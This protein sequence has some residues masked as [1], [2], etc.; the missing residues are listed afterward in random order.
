MKID[1]KNMTGELRLSS[2]HTLIM[3]H[4]PPKINVEAL[5]A[6]LDTGSNT[7]I[8]RFG[9]FEIASPNYSTYYPD[10]T[11]EDLK[12]QEAD[13]IMPVFRLL[14]E[15]IV[16]KGAPIDFSKKNVL[17]DSMKMLLGQTINIDH[18]VAVGNAIG[19]VSEVFWQNSYKDTEGRA[20]P[21]GINGVLKIDGKSNPRIARGIMMDPP[22]IHSNSVT[23]RF[24][25]EPSHK[26][27]QANEFYD[28][29]GTY[30]KDG[31]LVRLIVTAIKSYHETSL[32]SHGADV[33]AQKV[34]ENGK[35]VNP[36]YANTVY[37]FSADKPIVSAAWVDYKTEIL[38]LSGDTTILGDNINTSSNHK[39]NKMEELIKEMT[40]LLG[41]KEG[42][43]TEDNFLEQVKTKLEEDTS[44]EKEAAWETEKAQLETT[45]ADKETEITNLTTQLEGYKAD[46]SIVDSVTEDT[47]KEAVRLFKLCK[48]TE[49]DENILKLIAGADLATSASFVKQ[50]Q[51]EADEKFA[52]TCNG[53][54]ST[55][56]S[57]STALT[58][59]AGVVNAK[60]DEGGTEERQEKDT[61]AVLEAMKRK[62]KRK[63]RIFPETE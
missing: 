38:T 21:A 61:M 24:Q 39:E 41:L 32:V 57:R 4:K 20:I 49:A 31:E 42:D 26:Y 1:K 35:I 29:L 8:D 56:I 6:Q 9:L 15:T 7:R 37:N 47:R 50:Y 12:P 55:D 23:V 10:V 48:G 11:A 30:E 25:W 14:S 59:K 17:K 27:E 43:I 18:E 46:S 62:G 63:S 53:C 33:F 54:G 52:Q 36:G 60:G 51:K 45:V 5:S 40:S 58:T 3:G 34:G 44:G 28:K 2:G 13:F 22:S 16:S 19:A